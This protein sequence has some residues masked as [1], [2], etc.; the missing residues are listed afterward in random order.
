MKKRLLGFL[1]GAMLISV[2]IGCGAKSTTTGQTETDAET[3]TAESTSEQTAE[4]ATPSETTIA[5]AKEATE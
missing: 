3:T 1:L 4:E 2:C 5:P